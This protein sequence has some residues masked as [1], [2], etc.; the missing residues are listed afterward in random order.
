MKTYIA[1]LR[2][3]NVGGHK[4]VPMAELREV[5]TNNGFQ[6]VQTYIQSGNVVFQSSEDNIQN[7]EL[8]IQKAIIGHFG[9]DVPVIVKTNKELQ[10][11]FDSYPFSKA[12]KEKSYFVILNKIPEL[13]LIQDVE[14]LSYENEE[15]II[16]KDC[17]YFFSSIGYG[18]TKFNMNSFERKLKVKGTSRNYNTMIKLLSLS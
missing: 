18:R 10:T 17:I 5:L 8:A 15:F 16:K 9:F 6:K 13:E 4:K 1:L 7:I 2:G 11:I 3:I 12:K 14:K